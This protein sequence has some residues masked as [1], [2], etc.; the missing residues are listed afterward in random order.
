M[1]TMCV[2]SAYAFV[3]FSEGQWL[4]RSSGFPF[5]PAILIYIHEQ[6]G[7]LLVFV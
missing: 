5:P 6:P 3:V 1:M 2:V 7:S 4:T